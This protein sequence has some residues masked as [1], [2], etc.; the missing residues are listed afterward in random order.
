MNNEIDWI[1]KYEERNGANKWSN[2]GANFEDITK[3][4]NDNFPIWL[5]ENE[6][7]EIYNINKPILNVVSLR[8]D[9]S[10]LIT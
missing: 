3:Y 2:I 8:W 9:N 10:K 4:A 6:K 5:L 7:N 1:L